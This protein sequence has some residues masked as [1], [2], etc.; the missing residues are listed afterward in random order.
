[1]LVDSL[2]IAK[3]TT[4]VVP[5]TTINRAEAFW[6]PDAKEFKPERWLTE[7]GLDRAK[8]IQ[9]YHHILTFSD[10][11]RS[12]LGRGFALAE[13]KVIVDLALAHS[14]TQTP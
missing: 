6:G 12:C 8:D 9:G 7:G 10:G 3:G 1:M 4:V 11:P 5:S 2:A 14:H 13:L